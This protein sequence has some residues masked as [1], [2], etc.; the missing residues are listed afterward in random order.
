MSSW[1]SGYGER[2]EVEKEARGTKKGQQQYPGR[3]WSDGFLQRAWA[4]LRLC[5]K[6][7]PVY[8]PVVGALC[9]RMGGLSVSNESHTHCSVCARRAAARCACRVPAPFA[10]QRHSSA[11]LPSAFLS[12]FPNSAPKDGPGGAATQ[13]IWRPGKAQFTLRPQVTS[14]PLSRRRHALRLAVSD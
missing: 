1:G 3:V 13:P 12:M 4:S 2:E 8:N 14:V 5:S 11:P 10:F 7:Q 9:A 6:L